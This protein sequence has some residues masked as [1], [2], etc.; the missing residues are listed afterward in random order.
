[1]KKR[2]MIQLLCAVIAVVAATSTFASSNSKNI[3]IGWRFNLADTPEAKEVSFDDSAWRELDLPHD[4]AFENGYSI[5]G[6][7]TEKGGYASGGIGWYR[8]ELSLSAEEVDGRN[9]FID[10]DAVYM[11]S[12]VWV[13]GN[14]LG[15]RPYGY[16]SFHYDITPYLKVGNNT[17]SVR[18]DNSLEPS[19]RWYHGCGI[20][21]DVAI[22]NL[23]SAYFEK[24]GLTIA[25]PSIDEDEGKLSISSEIVLRD[26]R[27]KYKVFC[28]V[29]DAEGNRVTK[30]LLR[31][32][33]L[34]EGLNKIEFFTEVKSPKLWSPES[35]Y[36]YNMELALL[37]SKG[38]IVETQKSHFGFRTID[39][40]VNK[41][42]FLNGEQ[43]KLRGVCEHMEGGPTGAIA[44]RKLLEWKIQQIKDMGCNAIRV[45]HNPYL[46]IFYDIC[47]EIGLLVMDEVFD[48]WMRKANYDYGMQAFDEWWERDLRSWIRR[49]K[50]H[51]SV[52]L[53]SLGNETHG[54]IAKELVRVCNEEDPTRLVT[55][56][57]CNPRDM[58]VYGVNGR[59]E[60]ASFIEN[61]NP[62]EFNQ[63][64]IATENPHTWQVRGYYR[65]KTWYR[66]S[67]PNEKN[68]AQVIP[69]LTE[70]EIFCYDWTSP[71]KRHNAKQIFNSSYDNATV[72]V[73]ARRLIEVLRD[74]DWFSGSFRWTGYDYLGEAGYVHGGWPFRAFQGGALD[75]AGF[76]KDLFY[77][78]QS[79][80]SDKDMVHILPHWTHPVMAEGELIPV[81]VYTSGD[82]AELIVNGISMGRKQRGEKWDE[83]QLEWLVPWAEGTVEAIAY[84]G[85]KEIARTMQ[86][87]SG[88]P[89]KLKL[90]LSDTTL[91]ADKQDFTILTASQVDDKGTLYPYGENRIYTKIYGG[92]RI[93]SFE[94]G[95]PVD[96]ECNFEADSKA[97]FFGLNRMFIQST[98]LDE[99]E[100][101]SIITAVISGD[102]KL[103]LSDKISID[104]QET[105]LRGELP[106]R[107][108]TIR[109]STN[110]HEPTLDNS[111]IYKEPFPIQLGTIVKVVIFDGSEPIMKIEELFTEEDGLYWGTP[112]EP[113]CAFDG[114][115][116]ETSEMAGGAF[117]RGNGGGYYSTGFASFRNAGASI[118]WYQENDGA[119]AEGSISIR[120]SQQVEAGS[121]E[122]ELWN[123]DTLVKVV[124]FANTGSEATDW[125]DI[126][127]ALPL[128]SGANSIKLV[129]RGGVEASP[130]IDQVKITQ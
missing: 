64:F 12:E 119:P 57:D 99:S 80:W 27:G 5:D 101:V 62:S 10:F 109:Y 72:R 92:A 118:A 111:Y 9:I 85:G 46:P 121:S 45:A 42:M 58:N 56:G 60:K 49:D 84:R 23:D 116:A 50:N 126:V 40:D 115:Q 100:P 38:R 70:K 67:R 44:T 31:N 71:Q 76:P 102:K 124:T 4:W 78:Y 14:Y 74:K 28:L 79:Q 55:S 24:D 41:G 8:K 125:E 29:T 107:K 59:S 35:P 33:N 54:D 51:P 91:K 104:I 117:K 18:V 93:L 77:L 90:E 32:A 88:A 37:D 130:N 127:V 66:D 26:K 129:S 3:N 87:S 15:K 53:Y 103:M 21:G 95:S 122:M 2:K 114:E 73:T 17:I 86:R 16:I 30:E 89:T 106:N 19:A 52:F 6:A 63:P 128:N 108:F 20:Y 25:T 39:W 98:S 105:A 7:Q 110:G 94:S 81:W 68:G 96:V 36:L 13:N 43:Y 61:F 123:N 113:V 1:M 97:C 83:M 65:T 11:N 34:T 48:G 112:G 120:Y 22:R 82:E 69:D 75:L 47:D